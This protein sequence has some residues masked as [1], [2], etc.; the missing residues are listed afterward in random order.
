MGRAWR[1]HKGLGWAENLFGY[2]YCEEKVVMRVVFGIFA[3]NLRVEKSECREEEACRE[4]Q[5]KAGANV[6]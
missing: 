5:D 6:L 1:A 4:E 2:L 3:R